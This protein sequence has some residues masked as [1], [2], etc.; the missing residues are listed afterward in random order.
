[1]QEYEQLKT[2]VEQCATDIAKAEGGNKMAG[3]RVRKS[4]QDIRQA[5]Q[6][7]RIK[8]LELRGNESQSS[9]TTS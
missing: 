9:E 2:L 1:M 8:I 5:A 6:A 7:I 3:T 4:M